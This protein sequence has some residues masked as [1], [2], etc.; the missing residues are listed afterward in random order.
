M[1]IFPNC[2]NCR[3]AANQL[4]HLEHSEDIAFTHP[5]WTAFGVA[6]DSGE[7]NVSDLPGQ[8]HAT[9]QDKTGQAIKAAR[10]VRWVNGPLNE[11]RLWD[12]ALWTRPIV[13]SFSSLPPLTSARFGGA[14]KVRCRI[15]S[16]PR[17]RSELPIADVTSSSLLC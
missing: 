12:A 6:V 5:G 8:M 3:T 11:I 9:N 10:A 16:L 15:V 1:G 14:R 17:T 2:T 7:D 13:H 4:I